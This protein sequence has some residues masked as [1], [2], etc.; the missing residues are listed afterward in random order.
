MQA[1]KIALND[2]V[3]FQRKLSV[4][5][6]KA[7]SWIGVSV[8][9]PIFYFL[10]VPWLAL[11][12]VSCFPALNGDNSLAKVFEWFMYPA[13]QLAENVKYY[14]DYFWNVLSPLGG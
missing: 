10:A 2:K 6:G 12:L 4:V 1:H 7:L 3:P 11:L 14:G 8:L 13:I 5:I 9:I